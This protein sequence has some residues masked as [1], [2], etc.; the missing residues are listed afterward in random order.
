[1]EDPQ[2]PAAT[3]PGAATTPAVAGTPGAR[4]FGG[5][6]GAGRGAPTGPVTPI[7]DQKVE[8]IAKTWPDKNLDL[9]L[10]DYMLFAHQKWTITPVADAGGY[11]GSPYFKITIA[12]TNR[13]L[14]AA[15]GGEVVAIPEFSGKPEQL[16]RI[17]Q[18]T[19]GTW[20]IMPR[21][22]PGST[23]PMALTAVGYS[24]PTLSKF[25]P[26]NDKGRWNFK[27]P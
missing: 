9:R 2:S 6:P 15:Q 20:R 5:G 21:E 22:I 12:G 4:G 23:E 17:D 25:D 8:D 24:T 18:L 16:W 3:A 14:A 19:D 10:G 26:K 7:P 1:V 27:K 13:S 11:L